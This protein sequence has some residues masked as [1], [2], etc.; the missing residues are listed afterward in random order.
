M[1][2]LIS[3]FSLI[4]AFVVASNINAQSSKDIV[5]TAASLDDFSTLVTAVKAAELVEV[6]Q[7]DGPFT[8]FAPLNSAFEKLPQE[9]LAGLLKPENKSDLQKVLTYHVVKGNLMA[10]DVVAALKENGGKMKVET[11][12]GESF[13]VMLSDGNVAIMDN[14]NNVAKVLKTDVKTSNGV[15]HILDTVLMP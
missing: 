3:K 8:V 4:I 12:S 13:T 1:K 15:I 9:A 5:A 2:N 10:K 7:S 11:V 14:N 6:L